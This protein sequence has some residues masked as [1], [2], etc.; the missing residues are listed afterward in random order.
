[1]FSKA[2]THLASLPA[3]WAVYFCAVFTA[4]RVE[5]WQRPIIWI[6]G[7]IVF[8]LTAPLLARSTR[9]ISTEAKCV[10]LLLGWALLGRYEARD[11][12]SY[13]YSFRLIV[14]QFLIIVALGVTIRARGGL[15]SFWWAFLFVGVFNSLYVVS[16]EQVQLA[17]EVGNVGRQAGLLGNPNALGF[18]SF[19]G[20]FG[21]AALLGRSKSSAVKGL[22]VVAAV[23]AS[24]GVLFSGSRGA[25]LVTVLA[26]ALWP[27]MCYSRPMKDKV[28]I[29][30]A[31]LVVCV[32]LYGAV[33]WIQANTVMGSR[34]NTQTMQGEGGRDN[35]LQ[36]IITGLEI[37]G[38]HAVT[39]VGLG[40][41][42]H[43]R[44]MGQQAHSEWVEM[45]ASTGVPGLLMYFRRLLCHM[46]APDER[47]C[48][49]AGPRSQ[50]PDKRRADRSN[51]A[52]RIGCGISA[53][54]FR[55]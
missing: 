49:T 8:A 40:N 10:A 31:T 39:G 51:R 6:G 44:D 29:V 4:G 3:L 30:A 25:L 35:R 52:G 54:V 5:G 11:V 1:M 18:A 9:P 17:G 27:V 41:L 37:A 12:V 50:V 7:G 34:L 2:R 55:Y 42:W 20:I 43:A 46:A 28:R 36:L 23:V 47:R 53:G 19:L 14:Q 33:K 13:W 22:C 32:G 45:V 24:L 26:L 15:D 48:E 21:A 16:S 38:E